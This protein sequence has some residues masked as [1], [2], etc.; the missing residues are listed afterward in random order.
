MDGWMDGWKWNAFSFYYLNF[1]IFFKKTIT[2]DR[3][4]TSKYPS[5]LGR[6][7]SSPP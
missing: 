5:L 6:R 4:T 1:I 3:N 7:S 2:G